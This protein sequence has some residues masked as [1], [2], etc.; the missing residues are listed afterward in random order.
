MSKTSKLLVSKETNVRMNLL[1]AGSELIRDAV[2][3]TQLAILENVPAS[4]DTIPAEIALM[5]L[6]RTSWLSEK[7]GLSPISPEFLALGLTCRSFH[8]L[9]KAIRPKPIL[10]WDRSCCDPMQHFLGPKYYLSDLIEP[11]CVLSPFGLGPT[12]YHEVEER[13]LSDKRK[14][15][16]SNAPAT[17]A[18]KRRGVHE[19]VFLERLRV[20]RQELSADK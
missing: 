8:L 3:D 7:D 9:L 15:L 20:E 6:K 17:N 13:F 10:L 2:A 12:W 19:A 11:M 1:E 14:E 16:R 4:M 5:I 18:V